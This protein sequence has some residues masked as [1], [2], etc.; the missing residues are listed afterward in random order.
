MLLHLMMANGT[1]SMCL[2]MPV[3]NALISN[4]CSSFLGSS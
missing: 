1:K 3:Y 4:V 2:C